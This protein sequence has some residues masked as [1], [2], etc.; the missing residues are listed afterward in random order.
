MRV[1][2]HVL[3]P[4]LNFVRP[5]RHRS[6]SAVAVLMLGAVLAACQPAPPLKS[7][8]YLF[9]TSLIIAPAIS[10]V[11]CEAPCWRGITPG[12][13][14]YTDAAGR[15]KGDSAFKDVQETAQTADAPASAVWSAE[16]GERCCQ[17]VANLQTGLIESVLLRLS[18]KAIT[19]QQVI[20][21]HGEPTY[22]QTGDYS[23]TESVIQLIYPAKGFIAWVVPGAGDSTFDAGDPVVAVIYID[24]KLLDQ[25]VRTATLGSWSGFGKTYRA[26]QSATPLITAIPTGSV[27]PG[28]TLIPDVTAAV[29][30]AA[31]A[32]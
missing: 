31:T 29:T 21:K 6:I 10:G 26:I 1:F 8:R 14:T 23:E 3:M 17:M 4:L 9:D 25:L 7:D 19:A 18:E 27:T 30:V 12:I 2:M 16:S 24:P 22:V 13:S 15:L 32:Q 11:A 5:L 28:Q 20:D